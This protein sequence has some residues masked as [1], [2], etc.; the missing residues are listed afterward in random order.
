MN[1]D[2]IKVFFEKNNSFMHSINWIE[3]GIPKIVK[4]YNKINTSGKNWIGLIEK[5]A[6]KS[7]MTIKLE[8][9]NWYIKLSLL[10]LLLFSCWYREGK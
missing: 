5:K 3:Q 10:L 6:S 2:G 8:F 4:V 9:I 7:E 1:R